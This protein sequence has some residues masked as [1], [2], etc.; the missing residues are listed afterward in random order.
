MRSKGIFPFAPS[1]LAQAKIILRSLSLKRDMLDTK[2]VVYQDDPADS[3][4]MQ[5]DIFKRFFWWEDESEQRLKQKFGIALERKSYKKLAE[6]AQKIP[7]SQASQELKTKTF[8][9]ENV[10][11]KQLLS[12]MKTYIALKDELDKDDKI[13]SVGINCLNESRFSDTTPCL[14]WNLLFS[15]RKLIWGCEGDHLSMLTKYLIFKSLNIQV[16][17]TNLYPFLMG[18]AALK[19]ERIPDFPDTDSPENH[20]L[21]AHCGYFGVCPEE[22]CSS[23]CLKS[24]VLKIVN[25]NAIAIDARFKEGDITLVKIS[26]TFESMTVVEG[27]IEKYVQYENSDCLNGAVIRVKNGRKLVDNLISHH[28]IIA[29]GHIQ[30]DLAMVLRLFD[31]NVDTMD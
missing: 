6:T 26:P 5:S 4:G 7:D 27:R 1:N 9:R 23:W 14:A 17:M 13:R 16:M 29:Q 18:Q 20:I 12:A 28:Y 19:H 8:K 3:S 10:K 21:A 22:F 25:D 2:F 24:K 31:I 15:E 30:A 11:E